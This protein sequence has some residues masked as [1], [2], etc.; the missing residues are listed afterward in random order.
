MRVLVVGGAGFLGRRVVERVRAAGHDATAFDMGPGSPPAIRGDVRRMSDLWDAIR[1]AQPEVIVQLAYLLGPESASEPYRAL[2]V[3]VDGMNNVFE[4]ARLSGVRRVVFASSVVAH[5]PQIRFG[6]T[7]VDERSPMEP[8]TPYGAMKWFNE[9]VADLFAAAFGLET[10]ALRFSN[11]FGFGRVTGTSGP[12][13]DAIATNPA[14]GRPVELPVSP[15]LRTSMLYVDDAAEYVTRLALQETAPQRHYL[16]GGYAVSVGELADA[17]RGVVEGARISFRD[18]VGEPRPDV[19][20]Y[21]VDNA[22]I[23]ADTGYAIRPL[24][25]ALRAHVAAA[26]ER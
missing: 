23:V 5:G 19:P 2:G 14:L 6:D 10:V 4:A 11:L 26:R 17:V 20:V 21:L 24:A 1:A 22:R 8:H 18:G 16:T 7:A 12:W 3:N 15:A 13:A 9:Q 25:D